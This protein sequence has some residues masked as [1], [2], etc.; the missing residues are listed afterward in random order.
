MDKSRQLE[1]S[2]TDYLAYKDC[3]KLLWFQI[4]ADSIVESGS[5]SVEELSIES[6]R[7]IRIGKEVGQLARSYFGKYTLV[8]Y[9]DDFQLMC[10]ETEEYIKRKEKIIA[11][12]SFLFNG[13]SCQVD[14]LKRNGNK[15]D[16]IEVKSA[17]SVKDEY[18]DD[19][20]FQYYVLSSAGVSVRNVYLMYVNN[21]YTKNGEIDIKQL[22]LL[23][24]MTK[25]I[26][27]M[28]EE[29]EENIIRLRKISTGKKEPRM[30]LERKCIDCDYSQQCGINLPEHNVFTIRGNGIRN[31][32][33]W[34]LFNKDIVSFKQL[35]DSGY[36]LNKSQCLQ[37]ET[38]VKKL[39]PHIDKMEI[40][41]FLKTLSYPLYFLDFET[42]DTV[43]PEYDG[44]YPYMK[45]PF[46]FSL[47]ILNKRDGQL[48]HKEY[49]AEIDKDPR[50]LL[51]ERLCEYIPDNVC[52][53]AYHMSFEKGIIKNLAGSFDDLSYHLL[54]IHEN[55]KDLEVPF[56][57][58]YYYS[59]AMN[60]SYSIK[61]VLPAL[62]P[63]K[64]YPELDYCKLEGVHNGGEAMNL[65]PEL[66]YLSRDEIKMYRN[67]LLAYCCLD[68]LAM[69][70][71]I[72]KLE[73]I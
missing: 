40:K 59:R 65:F 7:R 69:V 36:P 15:Y 50:R 56:R 52:V 33:K 29:L 5:G 22:F 68:T 34:E 35:L 57:S 60:G 49:L 46:Q 67:Q 23:E 73:S 3:S 37:V 19:C 2:K 1:L 13:N 28:Q 21:Q 14:I 43:I 64:K 63:P 32:K 47:H 41:K 26:L 10:K 39:P 38:E 30:P 61:L 58:K 20:A 51:A 17:A 45:V 70:R 27:S 25:D 55:M 8:H 6:K 16:I 48:Q 71:I 24:N 18:Y 9:N 31:D 11:E 4:H 12:A 44:M 66:K 72:E 53:L 42:Y 54:K 62:L